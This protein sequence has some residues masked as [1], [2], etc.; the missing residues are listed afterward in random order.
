[1]PLT[2]NAI[3]RLNEITSF[4]KNKKRLGTEDE[5]M[6]KDVFKNMVE[7]GDYF[8]LDEIE[9]WFVLEGSWKEKS[10]IDRIVNIAHYQKTKHEEKNK[11]KFVQDS[12]D[13]G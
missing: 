10:V 7:S 8:G 12:C 5:S 3:V 11:L 13:C 2:N 6:I 9:S 4:V 1:M